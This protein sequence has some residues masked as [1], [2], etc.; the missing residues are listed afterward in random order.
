MSHTISEYTYEWRDKGLMKQYLFHFMNA[1]N[2]YESSNRPSYDIIH[3][4]LKPLLICST[5][6]KRAKRM[7]DTIVETTL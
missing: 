2:A 6:E 1:M 4:K 5:V 3:G 7:P